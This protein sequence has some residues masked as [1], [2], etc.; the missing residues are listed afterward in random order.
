[1]PFR[2]LE[3]GLQHREADGLRVDVG[4]G[5]ALPDRLE[6]ADGAVE[7]LA[8]GRVLGGD[9]QRLLARAGADRAEPGDR[10]LERVLQDLAALVDGAETQ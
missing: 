8:G 2:E 10:V 4:V 1:M 5:H 6:R 9:A 3:R 7:L